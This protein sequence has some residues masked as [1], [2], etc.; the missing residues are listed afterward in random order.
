MKQIELDRTNDA[1]QIGVLK[2]LKRKEKLPSWAKEKIPPAPK[3]K[4]ALDEY[5][6]LKDSAG[7]AHLPE[8]HAFITKGDRRGLE[9]YARKIKDSTLKEAVKRLA[10]YL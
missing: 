8:I 2:W 7:F 5:N 9:N 4:P 1:E 6:K 10:K 3:L